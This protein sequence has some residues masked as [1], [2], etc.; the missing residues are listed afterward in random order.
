MFPWDSDFHPLRSDNVELVTI[1]HQSSGR[2]GS[3]HN[4]SYTTIFSLFYFCE[5]GTTEKEHVHC[6]AVAAPYNT[7]SKNEVFRTFFPFPPGSSSS[8]HSC[9]LSTRGEYFTTLLCITL[10]CAVGVQPWNRQAKLVLPY[11]Q[12]KF[13]AVHKHQY[14]Y[15]YSISRSYILL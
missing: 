12:S 3:L 5:G 1:W 2:G 9:S 8:N 11:T 15:Y 7:A 10:H 13:S 6:F 14:Y 4:I